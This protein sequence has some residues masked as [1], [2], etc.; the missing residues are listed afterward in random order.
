MIHSFPLHLRPFTSPFTSILI[1]TKQNSMS[2][3]GVSMCK[4]L[5]GLSDSR[6]DR[7]DCSTQNSQREKTA[8]SVV[9]WVCLSKMSRNSAS[10]DQ[11]FTMKIYIFYHSHPVLIL[12]KHWDHR[13]LLYIFL[14]LFTFMLKWKANVWHLHNLWVGPIMTGLMIIIYHFI[15]EPLKSGQQTHSMTLNPQCLLFKE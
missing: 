4:S 10:C 15:N 6:R 3:F 9:K 1:S 13:S 14:V 8:S 2:V 11:R 7:T 5:T 12:L